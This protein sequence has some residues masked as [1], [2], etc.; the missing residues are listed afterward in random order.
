MKTIMVLDDE[1]SIL[2]EVKSCFR[3]GIGRFLFLFANTQAEEVR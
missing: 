3:F 1:A 2:E